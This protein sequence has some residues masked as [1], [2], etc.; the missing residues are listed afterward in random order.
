MHAVIHH[1]I[2]DPAKWDQST[3][4]I[5]SMI[6]HGRL[7]KGLKPLEYLPSV[8]GHKAVCVWEADSLNTLREFM[9]RETWGAAWNEYFEVKV[10]NA[11]G[12]PKSEVTP[13]AKAA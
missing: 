12:L 7:P 13:V 2:N 6:D 4:R 10:D 11:I 8:D 9:D 1:A 3:Q 5:M